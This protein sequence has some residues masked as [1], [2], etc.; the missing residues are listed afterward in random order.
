[1]MFV[2]INLIL[3]LMDSQDKAGIC[4]DPEELPGIPSKYKIRVQDA[5]GVIVLA[6]LGRIPVSLTT[7]DLGLSTVFP[8]LLFLDL[9]RI[10]SIGPSSPGDLLEIICRK[11]IIPKMDI[12]H[13]TDIIKRIK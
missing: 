7:K 6:D 2:I 10:Q 8:G 1:M 13:I 9:M 12:I 3:L 5:H 4:R 11:V